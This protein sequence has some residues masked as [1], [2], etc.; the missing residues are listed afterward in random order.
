MS[1]SERG[2]GKGPESFKENEFRFSVDLDDPRTPIDTD[3]L[4]NKGARL[5][6]MTRL[7][8][9]VPPGFIL[10]TEVWQAFDKEGYLPASVWQETIKQLDRLEQKTGKKFGD[11]TTPLVVSV[12]SGAPY[13]V[14][15]MLT[16]V[17]DVGLNDQTVSGLAEKTGEWCAWDSYRRALESF[18]KSKNI[19]L[20][21]PAIFFVLR[22]K[23]KISSGPLPIEALK[24]V[25]QNYKS[26]LSKQRVYFP[27]DP[28][29]QLR[30]AVEAV[31]RSWNSPVADSYRQ[32]KGIPFRSGTAVTIQQMVF[33]NI[34]AKHSGSGVYFTRD[35]Q[36]ADLK[37][38]VSYAPGAQGNDIVTSRAIPKRD[39]LRS[40]SQ[41]FRVELMEIGKVL[42]HYYSWPQE[43]EFTFE[44]GKPW[45]LQVRN[46]RLSPKATLATLED[47]VDSGALT[48]ETATRHLN[49][50]RIEALLSPGF[51]S[52]ETE[53]A[54]KEGRL[55]GSGTPLSPGIAQGKA[56]RNLGEVQ[57]LSKFGEPVILALERLTHEELVKLPEEVKGI[58]LHLGGAGSHIA[59]LLRYV[60][61][62][63]GIPTISGLEP[64]LLIPG[65]TVSLE[66]NKGLVFAGK[67]PLAREV[68]LPFD[69]LN[70]LRRCQEL[71]HQNPWIAACYPVGE[72]NYCSKLQTEATEIFEESRSKWQSL[73]AQTAEMIERVIP[74]VI[75]ER[76]RIYKPEQTDNLK[77]AVAKI[78]SEGD[79]ASIRTGH[80]PPLPGHEPWQR[81]SQM[82]E[83]EAFL[84]QDDFPGE[85]GGLLRLREDP[86]LTEVLVGQFPRGKLD[87]ELASQH[88]TF[89]VSCQGNHVTIQLCP[90]TAQL[91]DFEPED[92]EKADPERFITIVATIDPEGK[93]GLGKITTTF[94]KRLEKDPQAPQF[95]ELIT[96]KVLREWWQPPYFLPHR[97]A[98]FNAAANLNSI[99]GQARLYPDG[100]SWCYIYD[101]K[102]AKG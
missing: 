20:N 31:L 73:K 52:K 55:L 67:L 47:L 5:V 43:I 88:C 15:G 83:L 90:H 79:E 102:S 32:E 89:T 18:A 16:T 61:D 7:G 12:R 50:P 35:P 70:F 96:Q 93:W 100:N 30:S 74:K 11:P 24:E 38:R 37:P 2:L 29:V 26:T 66:A 53:K 8:L 25:V 46:A 19:D 23:Y 82:D 54:K 41:A 44:G 84:T 48:I 78:L 85:Y 91:R 64:D 34:D 94:G 92:P 10:T 39:S 1:A 6:E 63:R 75:H 28:K 69:S 95:T 98:A 51:D 71:L 80:N 49:A 17:L 65:Q 21:P 60:R 56:V 3:L 40:F 76:Y 97:M 57:K 99:D 72:E 14:P 33:G 9:P 77:T 86:T 42:E 27:Q 22:E 45:I 101:M 62:G 87:P 59:Q 58:T 36:S 13:S 4:G 81:I 68:S